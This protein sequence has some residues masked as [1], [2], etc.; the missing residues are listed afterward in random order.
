MI[1]V[2]CTHAPVSLYSGVY[3]SGTVAAMVP[4]VLEF[5]SRWLFRVGGATY[6]LGRRL[7]HPESPGAGGGFRLPCPLAPQYAG[8]I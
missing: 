1:A 3:I 5:I 4:Q 7:L 6:Y 8:K 2:R